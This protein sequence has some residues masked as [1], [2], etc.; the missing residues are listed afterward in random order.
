MECQDNL[1]GQKAS[2]PK[3]GQKVLIPIPRKTPTPTNKTTLGK[4]EDNS[5]GPSMPFQPHPQTVSSPP[6]V[7]AKVTKMTWIIVVGASVGACLLC[8][9]V[10]GGLVYVKPFGIG[11]GSNI[12]GKWEFAQGGQILYEFRNDGDGTMT[13]KSPVL[14]GGIKTEFKWSIDYSEKKPVL[15]IDATAHKQPNIQVGNIQVPNL[16]NPL[17]TKS[18]YHFTRDGNTLVLIPLG[19]GDKGMNFRKVP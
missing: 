11:S 3:C 15:L 18:H 6:S 19:M 14:P 2:C 8:S 5:G 13:I 1:A 10:G 4:L 12:I 9:C 7:L 17:A 16:N